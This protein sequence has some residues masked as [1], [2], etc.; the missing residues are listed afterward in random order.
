M[1]T[2]RKLK[3]HID[4]K[5]LHSNNFKDLNQTSIDNPICLATLRSVTG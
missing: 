5:N 4:L 3:S 2:I 1:T